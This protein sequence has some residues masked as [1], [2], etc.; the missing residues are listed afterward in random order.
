LKSEIRNPKSKISTSAILRQE[1]MG[2]KSEVLS[3]KKQIRLA[4]K[5]RLAVL[6]GEEYLAFNA[7]IRE[8]FLGLGLVEHA[9]MV[10]IYYSINQEV[11]TLSIIRE[12]VQRG[13]K[14]ALPV[15]TL[16]K[17]LLAGMIKDLEELVPGKFGLM[18]PERGGPL[19]SPCELD[20]VVVPGIAFDKQGN[21]LGHGAG[22]YD[23]F[24]TQTTHGY[25]L[26]L[27]Y[28]FQVLEQLPVEP[29]DIPLDGLLTSGG[30]W[31][32]NQK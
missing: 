2:I 11:E 27:G 16:E 8:K 7:G 19:L 29:H 14:V 3:L 24:L 30:F 21:R 1:L 28:E 23:R 20:L 17:N 32:F 13:K 15:C 12:L 4:M 5:E 26:G 22:Y 10:M 31:S 18:E 6:T 25:K 9:R